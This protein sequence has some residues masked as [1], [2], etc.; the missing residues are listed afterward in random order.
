MA[1]CHTLVFDGK[2]V[3]GHVPAAQIPELC[4]HSDLLSISVPGMPA[5]AMTC[6]PAAGNRPIRSSG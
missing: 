5:G 1:G 4:Q 3:E 2:F 6:K